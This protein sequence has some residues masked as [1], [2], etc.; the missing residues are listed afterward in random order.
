[1]TETRV[2]PSDVKGTR[3]RWGLKPILYSLNE[4]PHKGVIVYA[5]PNVKLEAHSSRFSSTPGHFVLGVVTL[6]KSKILIGGVYGES[7]NDDPASLRIIQELNGAIEEL[8]LLYHTN[9]ILIGGD[10]NVTYRQEDTTSH[11]NRKT[12]TSL[13]LLRM[14]EQHNLIDVALAAGN[15]EHTWFRTG[16]NQQSSRLDLIL[17][18]ISVN[19]LKYANIPTMLDHNNISA[20]FD[21]QV[22]TTK[23]GQKDF[24]LGSEEYIYKVIESLDEILESERRQIEANWPN[25]GLQPQQQQ[26]AHSPL[27][28]PLEKIVVSMENRHNL[29]VDDTQ[30]PH[31][32]EA[33]LLNNIIQQST[34][35]HDIM[36]KEHNRKNMLETSIFGKKL[37]EANLTIRRSTTQPEREYAQEQ[38]DELQRE[39]KQKIEAKHE[40][41]QERI[42]NFYKTNNGK[43]VPV[44]FKPVREPK[45]NRDI[46]QLHIEGRVIDD[47]EEIITAMQ[48]WY[49]ETAQKEHCQTLSLQDFL[50]QSNVQLPK[51]SP[52]MQEEL[53]QDIDAEEIQWALDEAKERGAPGPSGQ[54]IT[55]YKLLFQL[56]PNTFAKAINQ[57]TFVPRLMEHSDMRWIQQRKVIWIPKKPDS[58]Q[59]SDFRPLSML[60]VLYK[61]PSRIMAR[62]LNRI[63]PDIISR[64]QHGFIQGK[65]IQEPSVT[66]THLIQEAEHYNLPLQLASFDIEKAFDRV[67]HTVIE[68]S[69]QE[70]GVPTII[71]DT[72]KRLA[73]TGQFRVEVNGQLGELRKVGTGSGQGDPLSSVIF[74]IAT[75]PL[76]RAITARTTQLVY[77]TVEGRTV[78][79]IIYADDNINPLSLTEGQQITEIINIY[80]EYQA[81]SGLNVN[82]SKTSILCINTP[83]RIKN[84]LQELGFKTPDTM[85]HLGITLAKTM[86]ETVEATIQS[87]NEKAIQRRILATTPPTDMLHR[88]TL[89]KIAYIP[90][91][92]HIFM[93]LPINKNQA[94]SIQQGIQTFM[95]T[96]QKEGVRLQKR[97]MVSKQRINASHEMGGL[98]I[99]LVEHTIS[100]LHCNLIQRIYKN[101]IRD[102]DNLMALLLQDLLGRVGRPNLQEHIQQLGPMEWKRTAQKI[103]P[104]NRM[105]GQAFESVAQLLQS[106][107]TS[108]DHWHLSAIYGHSEAPAPTVTA[109]EAQILKQH[110]IFTVSQILQENDSGFLTRTYDRNVNN[111]FQQYPF[112]CHKLKRIA[113]RVRIPIRISQLQRPI[114]KTNSA[115][116]FPLRNLS[117]TQRKRA[118]EQ[119]DENVQQAPAYK[120]RIRDG[121]YYPDANTF[122]DAYRVIDAPYIPSKTREIA[123]QILNR[124]LWTKNKAF[125]S[126]AAETPGCKFCGQEETQEHLLYNCEHYSAPLWNLLGK[127]ISQAI[128]SL[129]QTLIPRIYFLPVHITFN[130]IHTTIATNITDKEMRQVM[131]ML[132]Q[133]TKREIYYRNQTTPHRNLER[134]HTARIMAHLLSIIRKLSQLLKYQNLQKYLSSITMLERIQLTLLHDDTDTG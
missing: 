11:H 62:R 95:W 115:F 78:N 6:N 129:K 25:G 76:N 37:I 107:E 39:L 3:L 120:T 100:G 116:L 46:H 133:E 21:P 82:I 88:A 20:N 52:E 67:G 42:S 69:L 125:K 7:A 17:T 86:S 104:I 38:Y 59:P 131:V 1:M 31:T 96:K 53:Q 110:N 80:E 92:N 72:V 98:E 64:N 12:R 51:I 26:Q 74:N 48:K 75:E 101:M 89:V 70:F 128:S 28:T 134:V 22:R 130:K 119:A 60:E 55:L 105:L 61:I 30:I 49:E 121:V 54:S 91:Y 112:L 87:I 122:Q 99:P 108:K 41:A 77:K 114:N 117:Q 68:Q 132:V 35:I 71:V 50:T 9:L 10:F 29:P 106:L 18:S 63:L 44:T 97:R 66:V 56:I 81:V 27:D 16:N 32:P 8:K 118:K 5:K 123:F 84:T 65:G 85:K 90:L 4:G 33:F 19:K 15:Q 126:R 23:P 13:E 34:K 43:I 73:L 102:E 93:A 113:E 2:K 83:D 36:I 47:K 109:M 79:P 45:T 14:M 24:I 127:A 57:L 40:A 103:N 124:T 58:L 111:T 94:D